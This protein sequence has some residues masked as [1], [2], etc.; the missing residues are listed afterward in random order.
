[1]SLA[2]GFGCSRTVARG[3]VSERIVTKA[4]QRGGGWPSVFIGRK[5]I[6]LKWERLSVPAESW[7]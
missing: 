6:I 2:Q 7:E 3:S 1:M 5:K 4:E